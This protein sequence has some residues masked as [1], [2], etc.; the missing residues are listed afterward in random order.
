[1]IT[2]KKITVYIGRNKPTT[3]DLKL[4][5]ATHD[6]LARNA[7]DVGIVIDDV[8]YKASEEFMSFTGASVT[9]KLGSIPNPP[10]RA[11]IGSLIVYDANHPLGEPIFTDR[12]DY[13]LLF[14]FT[15]P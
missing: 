4:N 13:Q 15:H 11:E 14:E 1:M 7:T 3:L 6:L 8:E 5:G 12:T 2:R 10:K 9:F